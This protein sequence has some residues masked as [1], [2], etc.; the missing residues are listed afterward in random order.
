LELPLIL[1]GNEEIPLSKFEHILKN[2]N[3]KKDIQD[4]L[5]YILRIFGPDCF[6]RFMIE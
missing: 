1:K 6:F 2:Q 4:N 3:F 5:F